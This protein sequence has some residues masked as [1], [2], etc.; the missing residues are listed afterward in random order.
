MWNKCFVFDLDDTLYAEIDYL[1]SAFDEIANYL[2]YLES[3]RLF[4]E[5]MEIFYD[6][7]DVF[8]Y[9][10]GRYSATKTELIDIYRSHNPKINLFDGVVD[11]FEKLSNLDK[12]AIIT[13]GRST[14][15]RNKL[16]ALGIV[17]LADYIVISEEVQ[18]EKPSYKNFKLVEDNLKCDK[19]YY[20]GDNP[21]KDFLTPNKLGWTTI[22]LLDQGQNIHKQSFDLPNQYLPHY[23]A[24]NWYAISR[25]EL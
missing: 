17:E 20:I 23:Y 4:K 9:L 7:G 16:R 18:S 3:E 2:D 12:I 6:K 22:C 25:L 5:M 21:N 19:Y 8:E 10:V 1:K 11:F 13:D 14:T 24:K 15:Q